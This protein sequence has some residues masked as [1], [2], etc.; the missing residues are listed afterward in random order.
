MTTALLIILTLAFSGACLTYL[1]TDDE[2]LLWRISAGCVIGS[3]IYGTIGFLICSI[4]GLSPLTAGISLLVS[5]SPVFVLL[6]KENRREFKHDW[7][8][9]KGK[10]QG[11]NAS[12]AYRFLY[13]AAFVILLTLFFDRAMIVNEQGIFTGGSNNLGDLPFHLG[14]ILSFTEG[15]N[16]PPMNPNFAGTRFSY[17]FIADLLTAFFVKLGAG[18]RESMFVQNTV[19]AFSLIVV[20]ERFVF[21]L[22]GDKFASRLA[23]V[24][25][26]LSGG[27]GFMWFIGDYFAQTKGF[28]ELLWNLPKDYT[29]GNEFRWGNSLITLFLTQ[30]SLSLGLPL[31]LIIL[32]VIWDRYSAKPSEPLAVDRHR[33]RN[34]LPL[35]TAGVLAGTLPLIHV[36]SLAVLFIFGLF[37]LVTN[38]QNWKE[39]FAFAVGAAV[40]AI[41][42]LL[43][44]TAGSATHV[45]EFIG[46]HFGWDMR[47]ENFLWFWL[48][49][50][51]VLIP[52]LIAGIVLLWRRASEPEHV[53]TEKH[54]KGKNK[55]HPEKQVES[56][57]RFFRVLIFYVPFFGLFIV[58]NVL[59][60]APWEWDNIKVLVYWFVGSLP[61][62]GYVVA[63]LWRRGSWNA[64]LAFVL[65]GFMTLAGGL[66]VWR[67]LSRQINYK[68]LDSDA[69]TVATRIRANTPEDGVFLN[70]PT[71]NSA[72]LLSGRPSFMRYSGHLGSHGIDYKPREEAVK[73]MYRGG[74][75]ADRLIQENGID[76][77]LISPEERNSL[78]ANEAYFARF[79]VIA[80][81]GQ[82]KVHKVGN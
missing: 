22:V 55:K 33:F 48:K 62:V 5:M 40:I 24:L 82:Y 10:L 45:S 49:N 34:L 41:P 28:F 79:P 15:N 56:N 32:G 46:W 64:F 12:K 70:A 3:A 42:E 73:L 50:T 35:F 74:P 66:D 58:S 13:Y 44:S 39:W 17:P 43:W 67:T 72:V 8:K 77:V 29:I 11:A 80:E 54:H 51:G 59:K 9:A 2:P 16:L 38:S 69:M 53:T 57:G 7:A 18:L 75:D 71:Y 65:I 47:S 4:A 52:L 23:P 60:L 61:L 1:L 26:F 31:A 30:R 37:V 19:W 20:L 27:L 21:R 36:H 25:F 68:V 81:A 6:V 14:A 78:N 63:F 76:F